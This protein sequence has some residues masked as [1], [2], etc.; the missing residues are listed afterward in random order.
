LDG[1]DLLAELIER[2]VEGGNDQR[3][4]RREAGFQ[5]FQLKMQS[6]FGV[7]SGPHEA[8]G[9]QALERLA[10]VVAQPRRCDETA[11]FLFRETG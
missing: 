8:L 6:P 10:P 7:G 5:Q 11:H 3:P 4:G 1:D 2:G 9:R